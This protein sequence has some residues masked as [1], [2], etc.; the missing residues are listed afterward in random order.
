MRRNK[1]AEGNAAEITM[2][3]GRIKTIYHLFLAM[4][5]AA[6]LAGCVAAAET[7]SAEEKNVPVSE[8]TAPAEEKNAPVSEETARA[9][10][11]IVPVS[12][13]TVRTEE[14]TMRIQV[15]AGENGIVFQINDSTGARS[16]Y[17]QLPL[18]VENEDFSNN[19]K[20]F[21]PPEKLDVS[22]TPLTDGSVG[23]LAYY[24]PWGD[25]VLFYGSYQP[26]G[27]LYELGKAVSGQE[28]IG[29]ISGV[30]EISAVAETME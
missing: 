13:E 23:T 26:N 5:L 15:Q 3:G 7:E 28:Y 12:E 27:S 16:L 24:E 19:E 1:A 14:E 2:G 8:E 22:D 6:A 20:T 17:E 10:E 21:Y 11:K 30:M 9:E 18:T 4:L 29:E 25:V